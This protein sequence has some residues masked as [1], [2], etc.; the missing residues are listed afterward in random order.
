VK[1]ARGRDRFAKQID[2]EL[3]EL[4][5]LEAKVPREDALTAATRR[6][7]DDYEA[8]RLRD[9]SMSAVLRHEAGHAAVAQFLGL[10]VVGV[11]VAGGRGRTDLERDD[12]KL[13]E[14]LVSVL[15]GPAAEQKP[16]KWL[17]YVKSR[18][19]DERSAARLIERMY[20]DKAG[21]LDMQKVWDDATSVCGR[22]FCATS[23]SR[24]RGPTRN[25]RCAGRR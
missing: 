12:S 1:N 10:K 22:P 5:T 23:R 19:H 13:F 3:R 15:A 16:L 4:A 6:I 8:R 11:R 18:N 17:P 14:H 2:T 20:L 24:G 21:R 7:L 9:E 25:E